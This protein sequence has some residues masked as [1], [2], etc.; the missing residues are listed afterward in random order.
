ME[1][2]Y[3]IESRTWREAIVGARGTADGRGGG[4]PRGIAREGLPILSYGF[5][6]FFFVAGL[7]ASLAM[8]LWLGALLF[9]WPI[10]GSL[11]G[12][13]SWHGHEMLFGYTS[14]ALAGFLLTTIPNWTGR[15]PV[16]GLPLVALVL[17]WL[18]GRVTMAAPDLLGGVASAVID[19]GFLVVLWALAARE[20]IAGQN[21]KNLKILVAVGLL[22][23]TNVA[24][25]FAAAM[26]GDTQLLLR[27]A[28]SIFVV[29]IGVVGGRIVPSF[30][31]N[32]LVKQKSPRLPAPLDRYD[33]A[34]ML[35]LA[36]ALSVWTIAPLTPATAALSA[37][38]AIAQFAR[39]V[40]W[41]GYA[42]L[43]EPM[44]VVLH[45]GYGFVALG[46]GALSLSALGL[47]S[48]ASALHL[49]TVGAIGNMT[50]AVMTRAT[51]GH[52]GRPIRA[53][54]ATFAAF[55]AIIVAAVFRPLAEFLPD[56]YFVVLGVSGGAWIV[57]FGIF[58]IE[59]GAMLVA[60][61]Q[62]AIR[63]ASVAQN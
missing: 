45:V 20:I 50:F 10:G 43:R 19:C 1:Q 32:W 60:P 3:R 18:A 63:G 27:A 34:T 33:M 48:N 61:R 51:L 29:L 58:T 35:V 47:V 59:Y 2:C 40:R 6:P 7:F 28:I 15:L 55:G 17:L 26:G 16:S 56:L 24:F 11:H 9:G 44:L 39:L 13:V 37:A 30:T 22:C 57:A 62:A 5:R 31:R 25:H 21:W 54:M 38:A 49:L 36:V 4:T 23:L 42:V 41:R 14:A 8:A 12:P 53:S 46:M 52:T